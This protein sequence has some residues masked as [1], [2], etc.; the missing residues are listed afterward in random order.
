M[1]I[2]DNVF[3]ILIS[4]GRVVDGTG[5]PAFSADVGIKKERIVAI[6]DLDGKTAKHHVDAQEKI[7][8]PGFIDV[9]TH[10]D[11][12]LILR[13]DMTAKLSQGVTTVICGNCGISGAPYSSKG[14]PPG[15]LRLVF[16]SGSFVAESMGAFIAKVDA[17][18]PAINSAFLVGH[19]TLRM[20]VM[21]DDDLHRTATHDE[22]S[23]MRSKLK[24]CL[25]QGAIGLST[26]LF[27][28][29]AFSASTEEVIEVAK[30]LKDFGGIYTTHMRDEA[31][32]VIESIEE[33]LEIG[34]QIQAPVVISHH[35]CQGKR[36]FGKSTQT[37]ELIRQAKEHQ[38][39]ALDVYPY[40][41][42]STVL[43]ESMVNNSLKTL[44]SWSDPHP[45]FTATDLNDIVKKMGCNLSEAI[46]KLQPAGAIYFMMDE[47]D[48]K[49]IMSSPDAMIG[50]DGLPE[51]KHPHPRLWGTFP[52]VLGRYVR[53]Q[54]LMTLEEG[55]HRMTGL[56]A[57]QFGLAERGQIKEGMF[58]DIT[59][60][61]PDSII[62][63]STF[64]HPVSKAKG[65]EQVIVNGQLVWQNGEGTGIRPGRV[66]KRTLG[67]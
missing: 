23:Q 65:I 33:S 24:E 49:R 52:R 57:Q 51:D 40:D 25:E 58:A 61:D 6:G 54:K 28:E 3:D 43:E 48:V 45:E 63:T 42:C 56:S 60:F 47:Q 46:Q 13:P 37:L 30:V 32:K 39:L 66:I 8:S 53:E 12:S 34:R 15:L 50:S 29:P 16:K 17:A 21:G 27:Y 14:N 7:V 31:D 18:Q 26:G 22:I 38:A 2:K 20:E 41:A 10:D 44:I 62:D 19:T 67:R 1:L 64:E 5:R 35:K 9:H 36:N 4:N 55:V 59:I 11:A